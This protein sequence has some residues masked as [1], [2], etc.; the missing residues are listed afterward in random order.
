MFKKAILV[1][2]Q[3]LLFL[4]LFIA[5]SFL[6]ALPS[7]R[8]LYFQVQTGPHRVFVL[9]GLVLAL[10]AYLIIILIE[11]VRKRVR[12]PGGLTTLALVLALVLG[13]AMKLGFKSV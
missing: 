10:L 7:F 3:T 11:V 2:L 5:G 6:P 12:G 1:V 13:L 9:D 4:I 8:S